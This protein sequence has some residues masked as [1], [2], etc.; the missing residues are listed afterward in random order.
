MNY[1]YIDID[2]NFNN[3]VVM[4]YLIQHLTKYNLTLTNSSALLFSL[5]DFKNCISVIQNNLVFIKL[6]KDYLKNLELKKELCNWFNTFLVKNNSSAFAIESYLRLYKGQINN[7]DNFE[8]ESLI[9]DGAEPITSDLGL[10]Q[11]FMIKFKNINFIFLPPDLEQ[12]KDIVDNKLGSLFA[13]L[14][15]M[16]T[17]FIYLKCFGISQENLEKNIAVFKN[18]SIGAS[19]NYYYNG[20][21]CL[22]TIGYSAKTEVNELNDFVSRICEGISKFI[23][24]TENI[25]LEQM[26]IDLLKLTNKKCSLIEN[27]SNGNIYYRLAQTDRFGVKNNIKHNVVIQDINQLFFLESI[28]KNELSINGINTVE[29][30]YEIASS[31]LNDIAVDLTIC[32]VGNYDKNS[33]TASS[34]LAIGDRD[35]IHIYKNNFKG[36]LLEVQK[37]LVDNVYFYLIRKLKQNNLLFDQTLSKM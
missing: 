1:T 12:L 28:D 34:F 13:R 2:T 16:P 20:L 14:Y 7:T 32:S 31:V 19:I 36:E 35:G 5:Q 9:P 37:A 18:N 3:D 27:I 15:S 25:S 10:V 30:V 8:N 22:L 23:Y 4:D 11:G 21:D 33:K 17:E 29:S 26:V 6:S 24:A